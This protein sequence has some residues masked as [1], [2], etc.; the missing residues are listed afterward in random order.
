M[1]IIKFI[2]ALLI[3][4]NLNLSCKS[5]DDGEPTPEEIIECV[6]VQ[7]DAD[8]DGLIDATERSIMDE[9]SANALSTKSEIENNLIGEWLLI[10]HGEGWIPIYSQPC[11][12]ITITAD[13]LVYEIEDGQGKRTETY[14]W[15]IEERAGP[16]G[17]YNFLSLSDDYYN[18]FIN[19]FCTDYMYGDATPSDGNMYLFEKVK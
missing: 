10:G 7:N 19:E 18:L 1:K 16:N 6:F 15:T 8:Q 11:G 14:S 13:E 5:D 3:I 12:Y 17:T 2:L 4:S 9:C